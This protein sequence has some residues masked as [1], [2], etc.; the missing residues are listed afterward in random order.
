MGKVI[1]YIMGEDS[2]IYP[3]YEEW[4]IEENACG[5]VHIHLKNIRIDLT[6]SAYNKFYDAIKIA[7]DK[8]S[9]FL[10]EPEGKRM[11]K[12]EIIKQTFEKISK[13]TNDNF[14]TL[15]NF[16]YIPEESSIKNDIDILIPSKYINSLTQELNTLGYRKRLDK[17]QY[18]NGAEPHIFYKTKNTH[19]DVVTGLY[20]RSPNNLKIFV[21][22]N[23]E[24]TESMIKNKVKV[25]NV[26]KWQPAVEDEIVHLC[27][28]AIFDKRLVKKACAKRI[29]NLFKN[30]DESK[31]KKLLDIAFNKTSDI[32]FKDIKNNKTTE[33]YKSYISFNKL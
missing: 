11:N 7:H 16:H 1:K 28:H 15:R 22:I 18:L 9:N 29:D 14:V 32:I 21:N 2:S 27:C 30:C 23:N 20:Y 25:D 31:V 24:L 4:T 13:I 12:V 10:Y 8:A 26:W 3:K 6:I 17:L 33:I 5:K 19:F